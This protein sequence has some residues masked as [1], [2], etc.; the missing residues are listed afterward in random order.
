MTTSES[1]DCDQLVELVTDYLEGTLDPAVRSRLETH[2]DE[3]DGCQHY[4]EQFRITIN[5]LGRV[6]ADELDDDFRKRLL[7]AFSEWKAAPSADPPP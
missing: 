1:M 5:T 7:D 2:L 3:C 6:S 4:V